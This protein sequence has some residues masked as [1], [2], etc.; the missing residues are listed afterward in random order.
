METDETI[1]SESADLLTVNREAIYK[2]FKNAVKDALLKH[3]WANNPIAI[4]RDGKVVLI[5]P[6]DIL[7]TGE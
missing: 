7:I 5:Q 1:N 2:A 4:W 3:K 6:E